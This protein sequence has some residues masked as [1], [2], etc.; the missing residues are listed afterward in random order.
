MLQIKKKI[1]VKLLINVVYITHNDIHMYLFI[2]SYYNV[3]FA[4]IVIMHV[5]EYMNFTLTL[6]CVFIRRHMFTCLPNSI[7]ID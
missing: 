2:K 7:A 1:E 6:H 4:I 3:L 5:C